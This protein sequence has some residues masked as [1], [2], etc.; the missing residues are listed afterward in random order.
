[1]AA[2]IMVRPGRD[3]QSSGGLFDWT[4]EYLIPRLTD[5]TTAEWLRTVVEEN[6]GSLWIP[7]LPYEAQSEIY[8]LLRADLLRAAERELPEAAVAELR[9]LIAL[10]Y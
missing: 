2:L 9:E 1:M 4:L 5:P 3:W 6:L 8:Q 10:T 7:D